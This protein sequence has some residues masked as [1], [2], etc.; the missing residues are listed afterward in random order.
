M[1][2]NFKIWHLII[3]SSANFEQLCLP[4]DK[5][6]LF[7]VSSIRTILWIILAIFLYSTPMS[8]Y[9][10]LVALGVFVN[11]VILFMICFKNPQFSSS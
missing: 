9:F 5:I 10:I 4:D 2:Y 7:I 1:N 3:P 8:I 11:I 6:K